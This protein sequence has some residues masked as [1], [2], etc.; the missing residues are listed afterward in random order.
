MEKIA[1]ELDDVLA[2]G[3]LSPEQWLARSTLQASA[4][5][6][7]L[8]RIASATKKGRVG[9]PGRA[10]VLDTA[11]AVAGLLRLPE[12]H[13]SDA[14]PRVSHKKFVPERSVIVSRLRP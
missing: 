6:V 7:A 9:D 10:I 4:S 11:H 2:S 1:I 8:S 12:A 13:A 14:R 3:S 5:G